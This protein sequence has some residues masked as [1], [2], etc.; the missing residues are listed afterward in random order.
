MGITSTFPKDY[1]HTFLIDDS[2]KSLY[3]EYLQRHSG[4]IVQS[5]GWG[6]FLASLPGKGKFWVVG[7]ED[8]K[9]H[10]NDR[11]WLSTALITKQ[12]LPFGLCWLSIARGPVL[13]ENIEY[14][15]KNR[16]GEQ[17][18]KNANE[19]AVWRALWNEILNLAKR[20]KAVFVRVELPHNSPLE[21]ATELSAKAG[22]RPAHAH[23][24]PDWTLILDLKLP[25][26][27]I[28]AQMKPKGRYNIKVA[29]K[30]GVTVRAT[31]R[32]EDVTGFYKILQGTGGR[33]GFG[34]HEEAYY[35]M[36]AKNGHDGKW[37]TLMVAEKSPMMIAGIFVTFY[38][39]TATY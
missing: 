10:E 2:Q 20:E 3:D 22:W 12:Q 8:G 35:Q 18:G 6:E 39:N 27:E 29:E 1:M 37:G 19:H 34:I 11:K 30:N 38:G 32:P 17:G 16:K 26:E 25:L 15:I 21:H 36:L 23:H 9:E 7:V 24:H 13:G 31:H 14:R 33:D 4:S 28:L 5:W